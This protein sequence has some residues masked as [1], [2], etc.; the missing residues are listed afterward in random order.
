M[1]GEKDTLK[2]KPRRRTT[3]PRKTT[4]RR[5][6]AAKTEK[7]KP[8]IKVP[9]PQGEPPDPIVVRR[10]NIRVK[11]RVGKGFSRGELKAVQLSVDQ[12]R[13]LKLRVDERRTTAHK[14]N[15]EAL[16]RY[17]SLEATG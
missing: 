2:R 11:Q 14:W 8:K 9:K 3:T 17:L 6:A 5:A 16:Q 12:A 4:R 15:I 1:S 7:T 13:K 10:H